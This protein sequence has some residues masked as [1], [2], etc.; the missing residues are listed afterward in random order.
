[1]T[2]PTFIDHFAKVATAYASH[3]PTYPP[4]L[5]VWLAEITP[6]RNM[7]WDCATGTGQAAAA[8]AA[9]FEQVWATDASSSQIEAAVSCTGVTYQTAPASSSGLPD[10]SVDLV[11][12][13]QALHWF[14]LDSFYTEVRRVLKP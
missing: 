7:A 11:T 9:H 5:F 14:D 12:V 4:E 2:S 10:Q 8:L 6:Q 13:A 3:R 1:M